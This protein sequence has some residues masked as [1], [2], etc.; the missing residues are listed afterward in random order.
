MTVISHR[1]LGKRKNVYPPALLHGDISGLW[2]KRLPNASHYTIDKHTQLHQSE[3]HS[4][5]CFLR[6]TKFDH[7]LRL[8]PLKGD[9]CFGSNTYLKSKSETK[10]IIWWMD[11]QI[12]KK[13]STNTQNESLLIFPAPLAAISWREQL[14]HARFQTI[15]MPTQ[16]LNRTTQSS[17]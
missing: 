13:E 7:F 17:N 2:S 1:A 11:K 10:W 12:H 8:P 16:E 5:T 9:T 15:F 4:H 3:A 6:Y 14:L